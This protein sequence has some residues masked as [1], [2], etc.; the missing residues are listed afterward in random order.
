MALSLACTRLP[1]PLA[2]L[3]D[4]PF[5]EKKI[6]CIVPRKANVDSEQPQKVKTALSI[7]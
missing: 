3:Q 5:V 7:F 1:L 4:I 2:R 6:R